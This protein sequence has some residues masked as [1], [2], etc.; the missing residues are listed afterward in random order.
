MRHEDDDFDENG[1]LKDGHSFRVPIRMMDSMQRSIAKHFEQTRPKLV[2]A[3]DGATMGLHRPGYRI[4]TGGNANDRLVR[5]VNRYARDC[6]YDRYDYDVSNA[7]KHRDEWPD[8]DDADTE[9]R[10]G[11]V[12]NALLSRGHDPDDVEGY[13]ADLSD[14]DLQDLDAGDHVAAFE[15]AIAGRDQAT[16]AVDRKLRLD[17]LYRHRDQELANEWRKNK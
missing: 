8:D 2:T 1:V 13:I 17:E 3:A 5:D 16:V 11:A 10:A 6:A 7:W 15:A 12:R 9:A 4:E 14:E